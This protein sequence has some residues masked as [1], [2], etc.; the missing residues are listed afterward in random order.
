MATSTNERSSL[1]RSSV[2][3]RNGRATSKAAFLN[4]E[5]TEEWTPTKPI[6]EMPS[7]F[8]RGDSS[9]KIGQD[10]ALVNG[11]D[12][13]TLEAALS[14]FP[15]HEGEEL[16][17]EFKKTHTKCLCCWFGRWPC[18][19]HNKRSPSLDPFDDAEPLPSPQDSP[20]P[21]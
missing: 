5:A 17:K 11:H 4:P 18:S 16:F 12:Y 1:S 19:R 13:P 9:K 10:G 2:F 6:S 8:L 21:S 3:K 14:S 20:T 7:F 15:R